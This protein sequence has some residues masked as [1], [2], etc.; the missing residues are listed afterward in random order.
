MNKQLPNM[1]QSIEKMDNFIQINK[2]IYQS[3]KSVFSVNGYALNDFFCD[4]GISYDSMQSTSGNYRVVYRLL[5]GAFFIIDTSYDNRLFSYTV[6]CSSG[7]TLESYDPVTI[8]T[9]ILEKT[10]R[11]KEKVELGRYE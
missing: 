10:L 5:I 3:M 4:S 11:L 1:A 9:F 2:L 7:G 8:A 6:S